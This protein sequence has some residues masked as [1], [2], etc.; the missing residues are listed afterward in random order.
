MKKIGK[1]LDISCTRQ[2]DYTFSTSN[3]FYNDFLMLFLA[4]HF[5]N[6]LNNL[7]T[8][9]YVY[10]C[11]YNISVM[12]SFK[13]FHYFLLTSVGRQFHFFVDHS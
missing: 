2:S 12:K 13:Y 5:S 4:H 10:N 8:F 3:A 6:I 1:H 7:E 11:K 9:F